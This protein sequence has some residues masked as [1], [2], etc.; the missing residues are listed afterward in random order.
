MGLCGLAGV[1]LRMQR[2]SMRGMR[3]MGGFLVGAGGMLRSGLLMMLRRVL[4]M[5]GGFQM[6][7]MR[8]MMRRAG[9]WWFHAGLPDLKILFCFPAR[10][11]AEPPFASSQ[12]HYYRKLFRLGTNCAAKRPLPAGYDCG[13]W[14]TA[15]S[16][17][18]VPSGTLY[19]AYGSLPFVVNVPAIIS[20]QNYPR[21]SFRWRG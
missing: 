17:G 21:V 3:V 7:L 13:D 5:L 19:N 16:L 4:M 1:M 15:A 10:G 14:L 11:S 2:V 12:K 9:G 20:C 18:I 6:M 8:G